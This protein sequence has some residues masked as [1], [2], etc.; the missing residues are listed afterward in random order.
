MKT[1]L[2]SKSCINTM[3][4]TEVAQQVPAEPNAIKSIWKLIKHITIQMKQ[5]QIMPLRLYSLLKILDNSRH[6]FQIKAIIH[7]PQSRQIQLYKINRLKEIICKIMN[8][9]KFKQMGKITMRKIRNKIK[10]IQMDKSVKNLLLVTMI[11]L[12][13][14]RV[15]IIN[16]KVT[17]KKTPKLSI[18]S[19]IQTR[20][21][22]I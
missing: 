13:Q 22:R 17:T 20:K 18:I 15:Q 19:C 16:L 3:A 8:K 4:Q 9:R 2:I 10:L 6:Q 21:E 11:M 12:K 1:Q 7:T 5:A 14:Q